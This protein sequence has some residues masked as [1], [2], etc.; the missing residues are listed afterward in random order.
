MSK[1]S[2][3]IIML[4]L[5][6][7]FVSAVFHAKLN[8]LGIGCFS[9]S[10]N[11][12]GVTPDYD[13]S[14]TPAF[15]LRLNAGLPMMTHSFISVD[16]NS[17]LAYGGLPYS[18]P[19]LVP[20][21]KADLLAYASSWSQADRDLINT[22]TGAPS[23]AF[24]DLILSRFL[25]NSG[26]REWVFNAI[27]SC[28]SAAEV[29]NTVSSIASAA[30]CTLHR[31]ISVGQTNY[32]MKQGLGN[33]NGTKFV[34]LVQ[35]FKGPVH[36]VFGSDGSYS[37]MS[38]TNGAADINSLNADAVTAGHQGFTIGQYIVTESN[39]VAGAGQAAV[40]VETARAIMGELA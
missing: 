10:G 7:L 35:T 23:D 9:N 16:S 8:A 5:S 29:P 31:S 34:K 1:I 38:I 33:V 32:S 19:T 12:T 26:F 3:S 14:S 22:W 4:D 37:N 15:C 6:T 13:G 28:L 30:G 11:A 40:V 24:L 27:I 36:M 17:R 21:N 18:T 39:Q 2:Q 20:F 25:T